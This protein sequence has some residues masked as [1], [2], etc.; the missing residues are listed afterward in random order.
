[1]LY[2]QLRTV[3]RLWRTHSFAAAMPFRILLLLYGLGRTFSLTLEIPSS[4]NSPRQG[5]PGWF[6]QPEYRRNLVLGLLA[7]G[8]L[9][10][11]LSGT[12][13]E[14]MRQRTRGVYRLL[15]A[16]PFRISA[17]VAVLAGARGLVS[18]VSAAVIL[19]VGAAMYGVDGTPWGL[20][21]LLP[22]LILG[23]ACLM[24]L[25][26]VLGNLGYNE[27][28]V[29]MY[30]NLFFLPQVI[31]SEVFYSLDNA[32]GWVSAVSRLIPVSHSVDA[33]RV[34]A[35]LDGAALV[36]SVVERV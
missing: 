18:L 13:F 4:A 35:A 30:N 10:F 36:S 32:P 15:K 3:G 26:F 12:A 19:D 2:T 9:G 31:A 16:T 5:N 24:F 6:P 1:M 8:N 29:A 14:V 20:A 33:V 28:Q 25:G 7:F 23:S 21:L 11:A 17:F 27:S 22:V 34:A